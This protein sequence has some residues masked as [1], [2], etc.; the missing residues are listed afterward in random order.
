[1]PSFKEYNKKLASL[2]NTVKMTKTMKMVSASKLRR[3][4]LAQ[5]HAQEYAR[6]LNLLIARLAASL[7]TSAHPLLTPHARPTRVLVLV[8]TSDRG[9]CGGFN[10]NVIKAVNQWLAGDGAAYKGQTQM[11]FAGRRGYNFFRQRTRVRNHYE[12]LHVAPNFTNAAQIGQDLTN[13]FLNDEVDEVYLAYNVFHSVLKQSPVVRRLLP[14]EAPD[15]AALAGSVD[16]IPAENYLF[17][18]PQGELLQNLIPKIVDFEIYYAL[19]ENAAGEHGARM[20]AMDNA[21]NNAKKLIEVNTLMRNR[22][23]QA[24]ITNELIEIISGAEAL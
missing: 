22:A 12:I 15:F 4:Q 5:R 13:A 11:S 14:I 6:Q 21:T 10:N 3:A 23:R 7:D 9:M 20:T 1:M 17:I 8:L 18:P 24:A 19:L 2:R 16:P